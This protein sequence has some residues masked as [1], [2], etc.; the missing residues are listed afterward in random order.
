MVLCLAATMPAAAVEFGPQGIVRQFCQFDGMGER[1]RP[2]GWW[3]VAPLV[4]WQ[5]EPAW[6][7]I[8]L[9]V[10]YTVDPPTAGP[11]GALDVDV[12]Y[13]VVGVLTARGL[14]TEPRRI[15]R[16]KRRV[17]V[18]S[19]IRRCHIPLLHGDKP[20]SATRIAI[21]AHRMAGHLGERV[22]RAEMA[23][24]LV[25]W[26]RTARSQT[27]P[28][29]LAEAA[30][31]YAGEGA[32]VDWAR[33]AL[34]GG[35]P[36]RELSA[37]YEQLL[38]AVAVER[39]RQ[40]QRFGELLAGWIASGS[41]GPDVIAIEQVLNSVVLPLAASAPV[42]LLVVDGM[43]CRVRAELLDDLMYA[44]W[45]T[46]GPQEPGNNPAGS[47]CAPLPPV[48]AAIPTVTEVCRASLLCGKL[49]SGTSSVEKQGFAQHPG[50]VQVSKPKFPP[51]LFHKGELTEGGD[52]DLAPAVRAEI[53][54][55]HRTAVGVVVNAVDD[56]LLKGDQV[57]TRWSLDTIQPLQSLLY[58]ARAAGRVV[59]LTSDHGHV[60]EAD[61]ELR[62]SPYG[63]RWR[64]A[65]GNRD[66]GEI[67]VEGPR[68][69][70]SIGQRVVVPWSE[71]IRYGGKKNGYHG[72]VTPQE[73]VVPLAVLVPA[74]V[75]VE[76]WTEVPIMYPESWV[77]ETAV[78]A[79]PPARVSSPRR[80]K[81]VQGTLFERAAPPAVDWIGKLLGSPTFVEQ[82]R[83]AGR[84]P[85]SDERIREVLIALDDHGGKLTRSAL[86]HKLGISPL[87]LAGTIA[88]MRRILNVEGYAVLAVDEASDTI[89]LSRELLDAQFDLQ[90]G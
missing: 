43:S 67:V 56:H 87:R 81:A 53:A 32:F 84:T 40:N 51:I 48:I 64:A 9:I 75:G 39:E 5:L 85:L 23:L 57:R 74:G 25:R 34:R 22:P 49:T 78:P 17:D 68:V 71:R 54:S 13:S 35:D 69:I 1:L 8:M 55:P 36:H 72:G 88:T 63:D 73:T 31:R 77:L 42:L 2:G 26:L 10:G 37:A 59:I 86:A 70:S 27:V 62:K 61:T 33:S 80:M 66:L 12:V 4:D 65:D 44:G 83:V 6:D 3:S 52:N 28:G 16:T 41:T 50:L 82:R 19:R 11:R 18:R 90:E 7:Q 58:E 14:N 79:G 20:Y 38:A 15:A 21:R 76:G 29:S 47:G 45:V 60:L 30:G 24:R 46:L 89:E